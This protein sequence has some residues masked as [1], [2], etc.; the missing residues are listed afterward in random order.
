MLNFEN[1]E[2][3]FAYR[4][5]GEL[6]QANFLFASM[7]NAFVTNI[8]VKFTNWAFKVGL[9]IS[10]LIKKTLFKQ[11]CGGENLME[12]GDTAEKIYKYGVGVILDYGVEGKETE[13][14]FEETT[15]GFIEAFQFAKGKEHIPFVSVKV[16]GFARFGLLEKIDAKQSLSNDEKVELESV[17]QRLIRICNAAKDSNTMLL[18]DAEETWIQDPVDELALEMMQIFNKEKVIVFNTYQMYRHDRLAYM[19]ENLKSAK[20]H[21]F[22]LGAK[23]VRGAYMEKERMR[24]QVLNYLSPIQTTKE[25]TD[26]DYN[27]AVRLCIQEINHCALFIG[28]HNEASC[29]L[30]IELMMKNNILSNSSSVYFSQ[31]YGMSDNISFNL[32]FEKYNVSKYLPYGPVHDVIPYLMRRAQ[33]N[34]SVKGQTGRELG[35]ISKELK[36]RKIK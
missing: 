10:G 14:Q 33:E 13:A 31:L 35:L 26:K 1:T 2:H 32:A 28:T 23:L 5:N 3:A 20:Q 4:S 18:I 27:D 29:L 36:R 19:Q 34:T 24:A 22:L 8:G 21:G 17:K 6:K 15:I 12:A 30:A 16:T 25:N 7:G 11:F 9:P